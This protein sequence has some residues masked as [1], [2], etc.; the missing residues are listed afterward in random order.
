MWEAKREDSQVTFRLIGKAR[1]HEYELRAYY[2][3]AC[4]CDAP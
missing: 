1:R 2:E 4:E 3:R